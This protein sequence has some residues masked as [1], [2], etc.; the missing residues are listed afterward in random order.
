M[1]ILIEFYV[2]GVD[3]FRD[4]KNLFALFLHRALITVA[5]RIDGCPFVI[6]SSAA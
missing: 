2:T 5:Q 4:S 6:H 3:S 1:I